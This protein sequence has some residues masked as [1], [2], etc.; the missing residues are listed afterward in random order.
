MSKWTS[1]ALNDP[2]WHPVRDPVEPSPSVDGKSLTVRTG[3]GTDWWRVPF[4]AP[5]RDDTS[6]AIWAFERKVGS[7]GFEVRC[8]VEVSKEATQQV[9]VIAIVFHLDEE[10][11]EKCRLMSQL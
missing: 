2:R 1:V 3:A 7:K 4:P 5:G 11:V 10:R 8:E 6:G 9:S